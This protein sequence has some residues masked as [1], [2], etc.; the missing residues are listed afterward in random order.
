[1]IHRGHTQ[2]HSHD[3]SL[4]LQKRS[5]NG[6]MMDVVVVIINMYSYSGF[7][8]SCS[9][10]FSFGRSYSFSICMLVSSLFKLYN[11][12]IDIWSEIELNTH[13]VTFE[14]LKWAWKIISFWVKPKTLLNTYCEA[15][16]EQSKRERRKE[17][18]GKKVK[19]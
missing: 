11:F 18:D 17:N 6:L 4:W 14:I 10:L 5:I 19:Q 7:S 2:T 16:I 12:Q 1:M 15:T 8:F 3:F 13:R 9:S